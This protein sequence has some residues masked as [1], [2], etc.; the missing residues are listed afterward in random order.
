MDY[1]MIEMGPK[2]EWTR[3]HITYDRYKDWK[4]RVEMLMESALEEESD[5]AKYNYLKFWLREGLPLIRKWENTK[6]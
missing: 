4:L 5:Q 2:L 6:K 1:N 3:D